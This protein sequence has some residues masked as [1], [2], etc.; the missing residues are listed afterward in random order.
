MS[1]RLQSCYSP[2]AIRPILIAGSI[3][4]FHAVLPLSARENNASNKFPL[5]ALFSETMITVRWPKQES[6]G[7]FNVYAD[8][9]TGSLIVNPVPVSSRNQFSFIWVMENGEKKRI[10]KGNT[11][12]L[13]VA[14]LEGDSCAD[15]GQGCSETVISDTIATRYFESFARVEEKDRCLAILRHAQTVAPVIQNAHSV[16]KRLFLTMYPGLAS[17]I[18]LLYRQNIDPRD[19]GACVPFSTIVA[20]YFS[21]SGIACYRAQ[22]V[23]ITQFHSFNLV[24]ID[25]VEYILDFTADQFLPSSVPVFIPRDCCFID[26]TGRASCSP[27]VTV[28]PMYVI[29]KIF[30]ADHLQFTDSPEAEQYKKMFESLPTEKP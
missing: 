14:G 11:V 25:G 9:G 28:T 7:A 29:E 6:I 27:E 30:D 21:R 1:S 24:V 3:I 4:V 19:N 20:K 12:S 22:G 2:G 23:F 10:V 17:D 5:S 18:I 13:Y 16:N 8:Y 26:S 15:R